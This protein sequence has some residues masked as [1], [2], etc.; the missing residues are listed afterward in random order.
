MK[1]TE[2][3]FLGI[4]SPIVDLLARV[5]DDF[6]DKISGEKG[7]MELV[8]SEE[9]SAILESLDVETVKVCGGSAGNTSFAIARLGASVSFLGQLGFDSDGEFYSKSFLEHGG[10]K[11]KFKFIDKVH[12]ARCLSL[13]TPDSERTM[14]TDLGAAALLDP[15]SIT[16][17]D[18]QGIDFVHIEGYLLFNPELAKKVLRTAKEAGCEVSLDLGSF[19]VVAAAGDGLSHL[20]DNYVDYVFSNED[21][22]KAFTGSDN[23]EVGLKKLGEHCKVAVVN[24]GDKGSLLCENGGL[25]LFVS[26]LR[27]EN[28]IDTTGAGDYWAA[29]FIWSILTGKSLEEAAKLGALLGCEVVQKLGVE[30]PDDSW[31]RI[32]DTLK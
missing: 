4:G 29:G 16:L 21:E 17:E 23:P 22:A 24:L 8:S 18:F 12:T 6:I 1:K 14:R 25:P 3:K 7:G 2:K 30:L 31:K 9:M 5:E 20:L 27:A 28:V 32:I 26:A 13:V 19:E 11:S 10:D 15:K